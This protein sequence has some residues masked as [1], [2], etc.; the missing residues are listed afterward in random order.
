VSSPERTA[1]RARERELRGKVK[2]RRGIDARSMD[3]IMSHHQ[4]TS[5]QIEDDL[6]NA[7][8][9]RLMNARGFLR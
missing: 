6:A 5:Q 4:M 2:K 7:P 8:T 3:A 1:R 9:R